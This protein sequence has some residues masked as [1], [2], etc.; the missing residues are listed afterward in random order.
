MNDAPDIFA[1]DK[2]M[3]KGPYEFY[4]VYEGYPVLDSEG[5]SLDKLIVGRDT[6]DFLLSWLDKYLFVII[7]NNI[8][9]ID[10]MNQYA[11]FC[12]ITYT[13]AAYY[14]I[15]E[16]MKIYRNRIDKFWKEGF[17]F[18]AKEFL[19]KTSDFVHSVDELVSKTEEKDLPVIM[20]ICSVSVCLQI[21]VEIFF[22]SK[23]AY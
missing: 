11:K 10:Y 4:N 18:F 9:S 17:I 3:P 6:I 16:T 20:G 1:I 22:K 2:L 14:I 21:A 23:S 7:G 15:D 19:D 8:I 12:G 5:T 13:Q